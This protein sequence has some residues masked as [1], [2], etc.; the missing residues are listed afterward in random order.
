MKKLLL[1][2]LALLAL[3]A[4]C[5]KPPAET[6]APSVTAEP[7]EETVFSAPQDLFG[8]WVSASEGELRMTETISFFEDGAMTVSIV[9]RGDN[10]GALSGTYSVEGDAIHCSVLESTDGT[11]PYTVDYRFAIDGRELTLQDADGE[12]RYLRTS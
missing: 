8:V 2:I 7:T 10:H 1:P 9:Y 5:A 11:A 6:T 4:G 12:A 3:L